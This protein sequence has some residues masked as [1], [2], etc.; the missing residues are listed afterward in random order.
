MGGEGV[1]LRARR[2]VAPKPSPRAGGEP[3]VRGREGGRGAKGGM[4]EE[5]RSTGHGGGTAQ[6][7]G[8]AE[9]AGGGSGSTGVRPRSFLATISIHPPPS[10]PW[11][12]VRPGFKDRGFWGL[13]KAAGWSMSLSDGQ[14]ALVFVLM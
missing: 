5:M 4:E 3:T 2:G 13:E 12:W 11:I 8:R 9:G 6:S 10:G 14:K 1:I 7:A